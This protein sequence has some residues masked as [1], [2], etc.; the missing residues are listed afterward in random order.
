MALLL[1]AFYGGSHKQLV[2]LL[3]HSFDFCKLYTLPAKKF[4]WRM[5][6][7]AVY[8]ADAVEAHPECRYGP[9]PELFNVNFKLS[10]Y[11][12]L[13][14]H[15]DNIKKISPGNMSRKNVSKK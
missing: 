8:F 9:N 5:R 7:S 14:S 6:S 10:C 15:L 4:P 3:Q 12:V 11:I 1:E 2:D 13:Q